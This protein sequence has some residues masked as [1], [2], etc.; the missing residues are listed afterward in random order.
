MIMRFSFEKLWKGFHVNRGLK[1][2]ALLLAI[3]T[4]YAIR[5]ATSFETQIRDVQLEILVDEGWAVLDRSVA[6][7][8]VLFR[9][10]QMDI[11]YLSREQVKVVV[12]IRGQ[13]LAG[14]PILRLDPDMVQSPR[15]AR[16]IHVEPPEITLSLD[17]EAEKLVP[18]KAD[19]VG[20]TPEGF[21]VEK[22]VCTPAEVMLH[23][24]QRRLEAVD[25]VRT[26]P[27]ELEGR[28]RSFTVSR[29]VVSPGE[30]W[31]ARV[32]PERVRIEVTIAERSTTKA[33]RDVPVYALL[34]ANMRTSAKF[35]PSTVQVALRGR[36]E[37]VNKVEAPDLTAFVDCTAFKPG[38]H[39]DLPVRVISP[40]G[41]DVVAIEPSLLLVEIAG[42]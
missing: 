34:P 5:E 13:S 30:T 12:D 10:A 31:S 33:L 4:W 28:L 23:G 16:A 20:N 38:D 42:P 39:V 22:V 29:A 9:G 1:I 40:A 24:P 8:D 21:E 41:V 36:A 2:V 14:S 18:V 11:R 6:D 7:V 25:Q 26:V 17:R 35:S 27:I 32:E 15:G 19:I 3:V 37:L